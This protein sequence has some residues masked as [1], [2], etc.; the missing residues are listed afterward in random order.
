MAEVWDRCLLRHT[1]YYF[2]KELARSA[3]FELFCRATSGA[4][5]AVRASNRKALGLSNWGIERSQGYWMLI[6]WAHCAGSR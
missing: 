1:F 4:L 2:E 6:A 5:G 3:V